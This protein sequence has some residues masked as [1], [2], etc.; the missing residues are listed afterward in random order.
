MTSSERPR[1]PVTER[2]PV[3]SLLGRALEVVGAFADAPE[4]GLTLTGIARRCGLPMTTAHRLVQRL[5]DERLLERADDGRYRVGLR[6]WELGLLAPRPQGLRRVAL[7]VLEDLYE[8]AH[9]NVQLMV[10]DGTEAVVVERLSARD[11]IRLE[12]RTGGRLPIHA[13]SGGVVL[14]AAAAEDV[15]AA[16]LEAP[17]ERFTPSTIAS[18]AQ[19]RATLQLARRQ[20]WIAL[21]DQLTPGSVSVAA[22]VRDARR[23]VIAAV[24]VVADGAE[25]DHLVPAVRTAALAIGRSIA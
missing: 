22:P 17:L 9:Q 6:L 24:S 16:V 18:E 14:L 10:L 11:A 5:A 20:G 19:L 7:P 12:G 2:E 4:A 3:R 23:Q 8:V 1:P 15:L 25:G 21:R 13:T